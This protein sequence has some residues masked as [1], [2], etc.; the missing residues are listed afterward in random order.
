MD[1]PGA[2]AAAARIAAGELSPSELAAACVARI[3]ERDAVVRAWVDFDPEPALAAARAAGDAEVPG[4]LHGIPV[5][6]KDIIDTADLPTQH[7][8]PIFAGHRPAADAA[9]VAALR[10]AGA[11]VLG[12]TATTEF[13]A[14]EPA[15]TVNPHDPAHTP[16]G[17]SAGSAA[18]VADGMVPLALG[19]QTA[20]SVVRPAAFCGV[21]GFK[22][23]FG[24]A[25]R[26]GIGA[27]APSLD[28]LGWF[29]R[30]ADDLSLALS[31]L[32]GDDEPEG[33][34]PSHPRVA[35]VP[36]EH[37][38]EADA[39]TRA[40]LETAA[41]RL[42]AAG[43][44]VE[45]LDPAEP[46]PGLM[47][48]QAAVQ[49]FEAAETLGPLRA[50]HE[51]QLS[52]SLRALLDTG[53]AIRPEDHV[54]AL[55]LAEDARARLPGLFERF[56]ALLTPAA[57]GTAPRGLDSTGD[58]IFCRAWTLLGPPVLSV[59]GLR[60]ADGMPVGVQ[61]VGRPGGDRALIELGGRL[62]ALLAG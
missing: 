41:G 26:T 50:D 33:P 23:T 54:A 4:P 31:V 19:T 28:T 62:H 12:K 2:A 38:A 32:V 56:D 5:G 24:R 51:D 15:V 11:I 18:A 35:V 34:E 59:P 10:A 61:L 22:A 1:A 27:Q 57:R 13:A 43:A 8:S 25:D 40:A 29:A 37:F 48:A 7:G 20:G 52:A 46:F 45:A 17:S 16:G 49:A 47:E 42:A 14:F 60:G 39:D 6:V 55:A 58:P 9:C 30:H 36:T 53:A 44:A 3:E 21:L